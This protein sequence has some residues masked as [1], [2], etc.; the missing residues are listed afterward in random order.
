[1]RIEQK[2]F[3]P[4]L[5]KIGEKKLDHY[6][7]LLIRADEGLHQQIAEEVTSSLPKGSSILDF[8]C[9]Q[10]ALSLR[11]QDL[12]YKILAADINQKDFLPTN[13]PYEVCNFNSAEEVEQFVSK[14]SENFDCVLGIEVIEHLENPWEYLRTLKRLIKKDGI[15]VLS[16]PN[17]T[18]WYS[19]VVF[20]LTGLFPGFVDP[21]EIGHINPISEWEINVISKKLDLK[22][23]KVR[24][25]GTLPYIWLNKSPVKT[26]LNI[27][28]LPF[29]PFMRGEITGW[30]KLFVLK[31]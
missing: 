29:F 16:T 8:G 30:C 24:G 10:G 21:D 3:M 2:G 6:Q 13:V 28:F 20:L 19:R 14:Y 26:L 25:A 4:K 12:G 22:T 7:G 27:L 11:L 5:I 9:G 15:I 18:S 31:K 23:L 17:T 1:M